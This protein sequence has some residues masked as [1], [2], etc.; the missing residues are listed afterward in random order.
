MDQTRECRAGFALPIAVFALVVIGVLVTGGFYMA[1]QETR[2]GVASQNAQEAFY[3]AERGIYTTLAEFNAAT[4]TANGMWNPVSV[5]DTF[6]DGHYTVSVTPMTTR[7]YFLEA[8]GT[9]SRGGAL[10]SGATR[11]VGVLARVN[12]AQMEPPAALST[13][14][15]LQIGGSSMIEGHD[16]AP[17]EWGELCDTSSV[18]DKPGVMIDDTTNITYSGGAYSVDGEPQMSQ[19]TTITT[20]SLLDFG[21]FT[22]EDLVALANKTYPSSA[23]VTNT[24]ADSVLSGG[25]FVCR[26]STQGNWGD[27]I[28]PAAVC[29]SYFPIIY[30]AQSLKIN[31][32][33]FGQGILLVEGDLEVNGGFTFFGPV[34][35]RGELKTAG[36]GGHFNGGV[37]AANVDLDTSTVLGN[38]VVTFSSCAVERALLNN[39]ALNQARPLAQRSWV[40]LSSISF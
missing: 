33:S 13:Q 40:D 32:S 5:S 9:V 36:T 27:P 6:P 16:T 15:S 2:I 37:V 1:R 14:G 19:D 34:Y 30:A 29:G 23:T 20:A 39:S 26:E 17:S 8:T 12:I 10:W 4:F 21:D 24:A 35:V 25:S 11:Q 28:N 18:N 31:S 3:L 38:A 22:W 7:L